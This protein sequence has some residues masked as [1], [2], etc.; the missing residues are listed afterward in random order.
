[1]EELLHR[2]RQAASEREGLRYP[3]SLRQLALQYAALASSR[4]GARREIARSLGLPEVT[5]SGAIEHR[6]GGARSY[7]RRA[8][9]HEA[10]LKIGCAIICLRFLEQEFC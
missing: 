10:Y 2:F 7:E 3:Q 6:R 9:I 4:G 5:L 8:D 1:M